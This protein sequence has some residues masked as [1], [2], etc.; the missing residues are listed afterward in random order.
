MPST[1]IV[2]QPFTDQA[3]LANDANAVINLSSIF[4]DPYTTG[5]VARFELYDTS[6]GSSG[7]TNVVL[8]D[9]PGFGAPQSV[10][11]FVNYANDGDYINSIIHRSVSG[12]VVQGGGF[13]LDGLATQSAPD[14]VTR[15][16]TNLPVVNEFSQLRSNTRGTLAYAKLS[17]DP[18]SAT[19]QWFFNLADN[20]DLDSQNGG[21]TVFGEVI[22]QADLNTVDAIAALPK[23]SNGVEAFQQ[24][25]FDNL[26]F[27][28]TD[29]F[30]DG[31][32]DFARYR[33]ITVTQQ[34]ELTFSVIG[35]NNPGLVNAAINNNQ[36]VL[37]YAANQIGDATITVRATNLQ[38][39][40]A[41]DS[42]VVSVEAFDEDDYLA[43]NPDL[44]SIF[45]Y[46]LSAAREHYLQFGRTEQRNKDTFTED[47]YLASHRDLINIFGYNPAAA[48]QHYIQFGYQEGRTITFN[49]NDYLASNGDLI[50]IFGNNSAAATQ[51][52][53]QFGAREQRS[54]DSFAEDIYLASHSDLIN[55]FGYNPAAATQH[56]VQ[57]G[58]QEGRPT[59][60]FNPA[61]YLSRNTDL[62]Q[63]FGQD[64][65]AAT[66]HYIEFGFREGRD[67]LTG[68]DPGAYIASHED[69]R[70]VFGYNPE[71][72]RQHYVQFGFN[73]GR[74][75]TFNPDDYLAS[76]E[77][78][79]NVFGYNPTALTQ[80]YIQ[81]GASELRATDSF[82]E[83][84]YLNRYS[85]LQAAFGNDLAAAKRHYI[86]YGFA[87][88][89]IA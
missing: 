44:I 30:I 77:D 7:V 87:E 24:S 71:A 2:S 40:T 26:P 32:E 57:F 65:A 10:Q 19:N 70:T 27:I 51:H 15:V 54:N 6:I 22:S 25:A 3:A 28:P 53:I 1:T 88:G 14:S 89:R 42:F 21:F 16:P 11:N 86:Q 46:N 17:G 67:Q 45:G 82:D 83:V 23:V 58:Y 41:E 12:F 84:A 66:R 79:I 72:G 4:D 37:D 78:L 31:D 56:Y 38:G 80:H 81:F 75:V 55:A 60:Q 59:N 61:L 5:L 85:D 73:E 69:L 43:S 39:A 33:S 62:Q 18:D 64:L 47:A 36:L 34:P 35:N 50:N 13:V 76:N 49:A 48:T 29:G 74:T 20:N 9:Q 52:Y 8:Y 63:I 68:F